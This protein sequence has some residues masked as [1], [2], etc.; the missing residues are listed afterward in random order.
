[1]IGRSSPTTSPM[2]FNADKSAQSRAARSE[3]AKP[4]SSVWQDMVPA[5]LSAPYLIGTPSSAQDHARAGAMLAF[6]RSTSSSAWRA[7]VI[8]LSRL[9][10][11]TLIESMPCRARKLAISG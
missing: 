10:G 11:L 8:V 7:T 6:S 9:E 3:H 5:S 2:T 1:M 4:Q